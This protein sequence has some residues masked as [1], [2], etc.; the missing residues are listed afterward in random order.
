MAILGTR[1]CPILGFLFL[2]DHW[3]LK[4]VLIDLKTGDIKKKSIDA[5]NFKFDAFVKVGSDC[6]LLQNKYVCLINAGSSGYQAWGGGDH[7][8]SWGWIPRFIPRKPV[9]SADNF[10]C[11]QN[12]CFRDG[13]LKEGTGTLQQRRCYD[14]TTRFFVNVIVQP[15]VVLGQTPAGE[16]PDP[17]QFGFVPLFVG[18]S[19]DVAQIV[20][21]EGLT[22]ITVSNPNGTAQTIEYSLSAQDGTV[23][24][25]GE[26]LLEPNQTLTLDVEGTPGAPGAAMVLAPLPLTV[27]S[28]TDLSSLVDTPVFG[29]PGVEPN[30]SWTL[31]YENPAGAAPAAGSP[32]GE[33]DR[34][35]GVAIHNVGDQVNTCTFT[36]FE[37]AGEPAAAAEREY[38]PGQQ[39][40][41]F[42]S[43]IFENLTSSSGLLSVDCQSPVAM[44]GA[45]Q[46][47]NGAIVLTPANPN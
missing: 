31:P 46:D 21:G 5:L 43:E 33:V 27:Q 4:I 39:E 28:L 32:A 29:A 12:L 41:K 36:A 19:L 34:E 9:R 23:F 37:P 7:E 2:D 25:S 17:P 14:G 24:Q 40:A 35:T 47:S 8:S 30:S 20:Q 16:E 15:P 44:V 26:E 38:Q 10:G 11:W 3:R 22:S 13:S 18:T 45:I 1:D 42:V 6:A